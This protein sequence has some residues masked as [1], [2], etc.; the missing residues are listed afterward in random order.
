MQRIARFYKV[1]EKRYCEDGGVN[2]LEIRLPERATKGSAGYDFFAPQDISICAGGEAVVK[3]G[4]RCVIENGFVLVIVPKSGLGTK[5]GIVLKN[6][7]GII[8]SDYF[9]ADNEGHI[10]VCLKNTGSKDVVIEKGKAYAQGIFVPYAIT[11]NDQAE[12]TRK[13]GF[14]STEKV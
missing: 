5:Q 7:V 6:T 9:N 1:S 4:V 11:I 2:Y 14:G 3:S 13:G 10:L 12:N 8:D